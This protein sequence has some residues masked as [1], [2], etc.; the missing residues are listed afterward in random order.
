MKASSLMIVLG[1]TYGFAVRF[2]L[3][4]LVACGSD[5]RS[6]PDAGCGDRTISFRDSVRPLVGNCGDERCHS[7]LP[8]GWTYDR[9]VNHPSAQCDDQRMVVKPGDST[10]SYLVE[11]LEA[12]AMCAGVQM[13]KFAPMMPAAD[14]ETITTWI[15]QGAPDN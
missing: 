12:R 7:G 10:N 8:S 15:C 6:S 5:H 14:L 4:L 3:V 1:S 11:K 13:P 2:A 9:L